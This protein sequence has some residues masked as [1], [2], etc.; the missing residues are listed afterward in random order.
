MAVLCKGE[1][2]MG[3][4]KKKDIL[5]TITMLVSNRPNTL[6]KCLAS[7]KP[8]MDSVSSE[9]IIVDTA[10]NAE[11]MEIAEKYTDNIVHFKWCN[12]FAAAR[13]SGLRRAKGEWVMF[14]DDDEWFE[15]ISDITNLFTSGE[16][17]RYETAAYTTRNYSDKTGRAYND[18]VAVRLSKN[19]PETRFI[20][21][22][23]EQLEPLYEP[24]YYAEAYVH[25]YGYAF[26]SKEDLY[27]HSWRN[28]KLLTEAVAQDKDNWMAGVHLVQ[29][30]FAV[31]EFFSLI[32][33]AKEI[34]C[35]EGCF[36]YGRV[37]FTVY[38][39]AMEMKAYLELKRY[40]EAYALGKEMMKE[41]RLILNGHLFI[42][43]M[44]PQVCLKCS[45]YKEALEYCKLFW[46]CLRQWQENEKECKARDAFSLREKFLNEDNLGFIRMVELHCDIQDKNWEDAVRVFCDIKWIFVQSTLSNTFDDIITLII[47]TE[48]EDNYADALEVLL[49]GKGTQQYLTDRIDKLTGEEK[50]KVL[51]CIFQISNTDIQIMKYKMHFVLANRDTA[52][53]HTLLDQWRNL[54]YSLFFPDKEYWKGLREMRIDL[55]PWM[56]DVGIH[57][58]ITLTEA[59]FEQFSL[60]DCENV[61][62]VLS[63]GLSQTDIRM[64]H[65]IGLQLEKRLLSRNIKL[66][67]PDYMGMEEIWKELYRIASLWVSC[68]AMLYQ[69]N[70]FKGEL[71][72]AL[73][74]RYQFAWLIFQANAVKDDT[75]SYVRKIAEAAKAYLT[76]EDICRYLLRCCKAEVEEK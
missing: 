75:R 10:G 67:N 23:H 48:Y 76:M 56:S 29:E 1:N 13:N 43:A 17:K 24:T 62:K 38:A 28:I 16:Y 8:L 58:W 69:E 63:Q 25:H 64:M 4:N 74:G 36:E 3:K 12:D 26:D 47:N 19:R 6:E 31:S 32:A 22:I 30:Y 61:F 11:C 42:L 15:D 65:L 50:W 35:A 27:R 46:E 5:L 14:I 39:I 59:L 34:R 54:S 41:S 49:K 33:V 44:M 53:L 45:D 72:S 9:L 37:D 55:A 57:E 52:A 68:A 73:P 21:K 18:R 70:V 40:A 2:K 51:Y 66:E 7:M 20:G 71:Q 60:A